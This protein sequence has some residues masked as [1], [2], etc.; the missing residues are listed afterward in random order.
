M[1]RGLLAA[2]ATTI[3]LVVLLS[4]SGA[5]A[6]AGVLAGKEP[7]AIAA[8]GVL[9]AFAFVLTVRRAGLSRP[10]LAAGIAAAA[11]VLPL[12]ALLGPLAFCIAFL[13]N[14]SCM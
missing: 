3:A 11:I 2:L 7:F 9:S 12:L 13:P 5:L 8:L 10:K 1:V 14:A 4:F 6:N